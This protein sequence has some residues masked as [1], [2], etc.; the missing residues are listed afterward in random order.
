MPEQQVND[1]NK[2]SV[3]EQVKETQRVLQ[4]HC[5]RQDTHTAME[6]TH[7]QA[8]ARRHR[9]TRGSVHCVVS[10]YRVSLPSE[11]L[12]L[13]ISEVIMFYNS[14]ILSGRC[15]D[16][17]RVRGG[18]AVW[19]EPAASAVVGGNNAREGGLTLVL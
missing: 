18:S 1:R 3:K 8:N 6:N 9:N 7:R 11:Y 5:N 13:A 17:S 15:R 2:Q 16:G 14:E 10:N 4:R 12:S 19:G